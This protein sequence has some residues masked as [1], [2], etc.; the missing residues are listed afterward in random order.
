MQSPVGVARLLR[1]VRGPVAAQAGELVRLLGK[2]VYLQRQVP[3]LRSGV[4][5]VEVEVRTDVRDVR[6]GLSLRP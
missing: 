6:S 1:S 3:G 2:H 4:M 5:Q